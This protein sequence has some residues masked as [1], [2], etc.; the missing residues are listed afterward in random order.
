[1]KKLLISTTA[2]IATAGMASAD[3][4]ISLGGFAEMGIFANDNGA[5]VK[6]DPQFHTDAE[7]KINLTGETDGG[8]S[9]GTTIESD[10]AG[11]S[12]AND[13]DDGGIAI[14]LKGGFGNLTLGDTDGGFDW[15]LTE[16]GMGTAIRDDHTGHAGY[17][18]NAGLDG[19]HDNQVLRYDNSFGDFGVAVS[20]E[21]DD[22]GVGDNVAGLGLKYNLD[23]GGSTIGLGLGYQDAGNTGNIAGISASF[24]IAGLNAVLNYSQAEAAGG[25]KTTHTGIGLGYTIDALSF[26]ANYGQYDGPGTADPSG[27]GLNV[28][29][30]LGGGAIVALG[31]GS[32]DSGAVGAATASSYSLGLRMNF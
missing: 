10:E 7:F 25:A 9:F 22:T 14:F 32:G 27:F 3:G 21:I 13:A 8:L 17:N 5:G 16:T 12:S 18:G 23:L 1:M 31:Y 15:A 19:T 2:L 26:H 11:S 30:A 20:Y 6:A 29:Y 28:N 24:G 4:H